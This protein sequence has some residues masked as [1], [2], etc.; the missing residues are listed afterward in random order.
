MVPA[1]PGVV[2]LSVNGSSSLLGS[3]VINLS[4]P[5]MSFFFSHHTPNPSTNSV[6][7]TY[8]THPE[9]S[10]QL[11]W[12]R[13]P[14]SPLGLWSLIHPSLPSGTFSSN[15]QSNSIGKCQSDH[16]ILVMK[17]F[18]VASHLIHLKTKY[19]AWSVWSGL[20]T[21]PRSLCSSKMGLLVI[22]WTCQA[23]PYPRAYV[24][25]IFCLECSSSD[26]ISMNCFLIS[27]VSVQRS[28]SQRG[29]S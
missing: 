1:L 10:Y 13:S 5:L 21:C 17:I 24:P 19:S 3:Q 29:L 22:G 7:F 11:P 16:V 18:Q 23:C 27:S 12:S 2:P 15:N 14:P 6:G 4:L 9:S 25:T 20:I 26:I 8:K 28:P